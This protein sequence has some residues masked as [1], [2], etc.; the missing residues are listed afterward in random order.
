MIEKKGIDPT[1]IDNF[2]NYVL[3]SNNTYVIKVGAK[4]R[5]YMIQEVS[6][7]MKGQVKDDFFTKFTELFFN[8]ESGNVIF[9][10]LKQRDLKRW[11]GQRNLPMTDA[12]KYL[13]ELSEANAVVFL[14][15]VID[16]ENKVFKF[17]VGEIN[18]DDEDED[19]EDNVVYDEKKSIA[20]T[21]L[22][23]KYENWCSVNGEK[24]FSSKIFGVQAKSILGSKK[25]SRI[26][27]FIK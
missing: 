26:M 21:E 20:A 16:K 3:L 13:S 9:S 1:R 23:Q 19:N 7:E 14:K 15:S 4:D 12:K 10:Y 5:H 2:V 25:S 6:D 8:Q 27:Y 22:Y 18:D 17:R 11:G 24:A